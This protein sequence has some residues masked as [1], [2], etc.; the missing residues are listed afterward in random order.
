MPLFPFNI[1]R[2]QVRN[3]I[4]V[5]F[6]ILFREVSS[7]RISFLVRDIYAYI[8]LPVRLLSRSWSWTWSG[9]LATFCCFF[10][11]R[12]LVLEG[13]MEPSGLLRSFS[14]VGDKILLWSS[15]LEGEVPYV[16][17][18][19]IWWPKLAQ[20]TFS[21]SPTQFAVYPELAQH[22]VH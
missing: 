9:G 7:L 12:L 1:L 13:F 11:V 5:Y 6:R 21:A 18:G 20:F 2:F 3:G 19:I 14:I 4:C 17:A 15:Q 16:C 8:P 22:Q 10:W